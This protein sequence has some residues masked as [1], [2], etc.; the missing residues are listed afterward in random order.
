MKDKRYS[1]FKKYYK[2]NLAKLG[3]INYNDSI[4]IKCNG[5]ETFYFALNNESINILNEWIKNINN[6]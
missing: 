2:D 3:E 1:M 5:K 6:E 4:Q